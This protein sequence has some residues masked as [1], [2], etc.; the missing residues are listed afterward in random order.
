[1]LWD[2][3]WFISNAPRRYRLR[4]AF[5]GEQIRGRPV[6]AAHVIAHLNDSGHLI[7]VPADV[8]F[9]DRLRELMPYATDRELAVL[10]DALD[11][12][13]PISL[14]EWARRTLATQSKVTA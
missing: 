14:R 12:E 2:R 10:F 6:R 11:R 1:M 13:G 9:P 7:R 4:S 5:D 3:P 8:S